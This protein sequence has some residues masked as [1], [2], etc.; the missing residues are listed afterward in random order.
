M[1]IT[2]TTDHTA[3]NGPTLVVVTVLIAV[4][5]IFIFIILI[6]WILMKR[7]QRRIE[8][9]VELRARQGGSAAGSRVST[10][11]R[12]GDASRSKERV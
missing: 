3:L 4:L 9:L 11:E 10:G 2:P 5:G 12:G 7:E 6:Q 8:D 1:A